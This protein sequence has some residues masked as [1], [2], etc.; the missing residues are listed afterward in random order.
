MR[1]PA[2]QHEAPADAQFCPEC[3]TKLV[4]TCA[5]CATENGPGH[6]F[7]KHCGAALGPARDAA[8]FASPQAYTPKHLADKILTSK[9]ALE[10][11]RKQVT[12]LFCDIAN[13]TGLAE[14][15]GPEAMHDLLD[16]FFEL[17]LSEIHRYEGTVNQFLGDGFMALFGAPLAHEDDARR[18][19]LAALGIQRRLRERRSDLVRAGVDDLAVRMGVNTGFVVVGRIGDNLRMDYTA[20]GDTTNLAARLQQLAEPGAILLS[21]TTHR[22]L[23]GAMRTE[24]LAP[25]HV[26]GKA[27]PVTAYRL[28]G[29][30]PR[31]SPVEE[32]DARTLADFVGREREMGVLR[33][34]WAQVVGEQGQVVGIAG[35]PGIGK[36]RLLYEFRRALGGTPV[37]FLEGRCVSYGAS[38]PYLPWLDILRNNCGIVDSDTPEAVAEKVTAGL[39]EVGMA[40]ESAM[41]L[42]HLLGVKDATGALEVLSPEAIKTRTFDTLRM[43]SLKGS[44]RR[45]I[46]FLIEDLH[47]L[48]KTSEEYLAFFVESLTAAPI[49]LITTY[50]PGYRPPWID[51]SYAT[52]L[53]LRPLARE[54]SLAVVRSMLG[55]EDMTSIVSETILSKAEG[56]PF[57]LEE[58][59]LAMA[60][61]RGSDQVV[62]DTV[63]GVIMARID[64]LSEGAKRLVQTA[65]VLGR[66][67]SAKLLDKIWDGGGA[68]HPHLLELKRLEFLYESAGGEEAVYVFKHALTQDVAYDGLLTHRRQSLHGAAARALEEIYADRLEEAYG[69]LAYHYARSEV[70]DKA[71]GYLS[72]V[73]D[74]AARVYANVEALTHLG[75]A[76]VHLERL[77]E[78][79]ERD[80]LLIDVVLRQGFSLYFLGRFQESVD[81]LI[82]HRDRLESLRD[83]AVAGPYHFW[84]AHMYT[85][86]GHQD[87]ARASAHR[88]IEEAKRCG[89]RATLG[90]AHGLLALDYYWAGKSVEG[91]EHGREALVLLEETSQHWWLG[92][93]HFYVA[94]NYLL[95]GRFAGCEE[96]AGQARAVG[97][98]IGDPR[99]QCYAAFTVGWMAATRGE[100]GGAREACE[101]SRKLSPDPV[102]RVYA[103][104]F[105]G[106]AHVEAGDLTAAIPLLES[107][108]AELERF[109]FPQWHGMFTTL[110]GDAYRQ[111]GEFDRAVALANQGIAITTRCG[112]LLGV[113]LGQRILGR[114]AIGRGALG[115]AE[116]ALTEALR[117]FD[118]IESE[119]EI[120]RT[121]LELAGVAF[122][123]GR[124]ATARSLLREAHRTFVAASVPAYVRRAEQLAAERGV[125]LP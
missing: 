26:K 101:R 59:A 105:L 23:H 18:A 113:G 91:L 11:E 82:Q 20:I 25:M 65:S 112:Y 36:S 92:M 3:G 38:I 40:P 96:A 110:L 115:E 7:C 14:R 15:I 8:K 81:V 31:R 75:E 53:S 13:S 4:V 84:L 109:G 64:R 48:D 6:K 17:C 55:A 50:R 77:P 61:R 12:V 89:D 90:K 118:S 98:T 46:I 100:H 19:A 95:L 62:P 120:A 76:L 99:L 22:M 70:A 74:K 97:E 114:I 88:A 51:R 54:A 78:G 68:L 27:E 2:C 86:L 41:Y 28:L 35:E 10:G 34:L 73:A 52:Q 42:L 43:L 93:A 39:N 67:F 123:R 122:G 21:D 125:S 37:T 79:A 45:P 60:E 80:R 1:C 116:A 71:V 49:F 121:R 29:L 44:R 94:M 69:A 30:A 106:L 66:E 104:G 24:R 85:R 56:N 107:A 102:S 111:R 33:D 47:W 16:R 57:F 9:T 63:Q 32:R 87:M 5:Q 72:R 124:D 108:I 103:T 117:T 119:F 83:P 58:L